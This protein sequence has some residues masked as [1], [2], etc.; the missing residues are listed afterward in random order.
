MKREE[1]C[2]NNQRRVILILTNERPA[3]L[4]LVSALGLKEGL[5]VLQTPDGECLRGI[6]LEE[7][8]LHPDYLRHPEGA[9]EGSEAGKELVLD[10][11]NLIIV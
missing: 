5:G 10:L 11:D 9:R 7:D 4:P 3:C 6:V 8:S 2:H 1:C